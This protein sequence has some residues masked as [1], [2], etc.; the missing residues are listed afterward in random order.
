MRVTVV[1][2]IPIIVYDT[3]FQRIG[4]PLMPIWDGKWGD[5]LA[6][7][8]FIDPPTGIALRD[9]LFKLN[10]GKVPTEPEKYQI[11]RW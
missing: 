11:I 2:V 3:Y 1:D 9:V 7:K 5:L 4:N 8:D 6:Q 10:G